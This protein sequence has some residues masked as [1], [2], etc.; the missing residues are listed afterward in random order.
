MVNFRC[1]GRVGSSAIVGDDVAGCWS[2]VGHW[3]AKIVLNFVEFSESNHAVS[4][5]V[6]IST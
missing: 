5:N 6:L 2:V 4:G 3:G 1:H